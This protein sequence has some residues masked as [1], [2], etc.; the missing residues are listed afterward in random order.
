[1]SLYVRGDFHCC[2]NALSGDS[3]S[4]CQYGCKY[5]FI[6]DAY[7]TY[8]KKK[9][10]AGF[11]PY[12]NDMLERTLRFAF[13][14][15][16]GAKNPVAL[17]LRAGLPVILGRKSEPFCKSE[18][19]FKATLKNLRI[20]KEYDVPTV[21]ETKGL[22]PPREAE[23]F[24]L[25]SEMTSAVN[26]TI[27]P[28][29]DELSK[30]LNEPTT[31]SERLRFAHFLKDSGIRVGITGEPII[32][33]VNDGSKQIFEWAENCRE[34]KP[35]H[36]NFGDFRIGTLKFVNRRMKEAG[37]DLVEIVRRK[38]ESWID[39]GND[40]FKIL[41]QFGLKVTTPDWINFGFMNDTES[42][43]G[44]REEP[45]KFH[46]FTFQHAMIEIKKRGRV[47]FGRIAKENIF[48]EAFLNKFREIWNGKGGYFNLSDIEGV[49]RLGF[50]GEGDVIYGRVKGLEEVFA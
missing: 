27:T 41:H 28:G 46:K 6:L 17:G 50:D 47:T 44:F 1:M 7:E 10:D 31:Y 42:C 5:C 19:E 48:G 36:V 14:S 34:L 40:I 15:R 35:S 13:R 18:S 37:Y 49:G 29:D 33:G 30:K 2:P 43:C 26:I 21:I 32:S 22:P 23:Y 4:I 45:F 25:L 11:L 9:A 3:Y 39:R 16:K 24:K 38:K 8:L 20:F 12:N